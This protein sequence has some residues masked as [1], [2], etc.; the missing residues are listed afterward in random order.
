MTDVYVVE[1]HD[2]LP[3]GHETIDSIYATEADAQ[4]RVEELG[5]L[6]NCDITRWPVLERTEAA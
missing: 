2:G 6:S 1:R 3:G 5:P 4:K